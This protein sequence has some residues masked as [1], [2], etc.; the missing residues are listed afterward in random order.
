MSKEWMNAW[1]YEM[2][3][4]KNEC[5]VPLQEV[6]DIRF[7][8]DSGKWCGQSHGNLGSVR[9]CSALDRLSTGGHFN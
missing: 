9:D 7:N 5:G 1:V 2:N 3:R 4:F 8:A 6:N